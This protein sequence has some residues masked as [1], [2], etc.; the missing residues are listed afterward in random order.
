MNGIEI[1]DLK[2]KLEHAQMTN[3]IYVVLMLIFAFAFCIGSFL[4]SSFNGELI[5]KI[6]KLNAENSQLKIERDVLLNVRCAE[7]PDETGDEV[8]VD[9]AGSFS[10]RLNK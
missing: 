2:S 4:Q 8:N 9:N 6:T 10:A 1:A 5:S 3:G 7:Q